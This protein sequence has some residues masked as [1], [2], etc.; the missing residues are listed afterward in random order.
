MNVLGKNIFKL[1]LEE[2]QGPSLCFQKIKGIVQ[3]QELSY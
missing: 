2:S 1:D 3:T